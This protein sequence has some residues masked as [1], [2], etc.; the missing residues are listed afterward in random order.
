MITV[1]VCGFSRSG[2]SVVAR[3]LAHNGMG[4]P[5]EWLNH[6]T[7]LPEDQRG[8]FLKQLIEENRRGEFFG[9]KATPTV[10][11][12]WHDRLKPDFYLFLWR[13][14]QILQA[15]SDYKLSIN[16]QAGIGVGQS[17]SEIPVPYDDEEI[18]RRYWQIVNGTAAYRKELDDAG[19]KYLAVRYEDLISDEGKRQFVKQCAEHFGVE[20]KNEIDID[21]GMRPQ[22]N[23]QS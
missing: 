1:M 3:L 12:S 7:E 11:H 17:E 14:N 2:T 20:L 6:H 8:G 13:E 23:E 9:V 16:G 19:I 4:Y 5:D 21:I 18:L 22:R 15:I 10:F